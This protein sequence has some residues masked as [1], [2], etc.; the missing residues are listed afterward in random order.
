MIQKLINKISLISFLIIIIGFSVKAQKSKGNLD[1]SFIASIYTIT[2]GECVN[3]TDMSTGG[4]T[5]WQWS[6]PGAPDLS[7]LV[8]Q[9]QVF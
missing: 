8:R 2:A 3:F 9:I 5:A 6:F 4:P 7:F 1:A